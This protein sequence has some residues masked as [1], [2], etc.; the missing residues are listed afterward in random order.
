MPEDRQNPLGD[1]RVVHSDFTDV[2]GKLRMSDHL[3]RSVAAAGSPEVR[4]GQPL[5]FPGL[6]VFEAL[7]SILITDMMRADVKVL[8]ERR[9]QLRPI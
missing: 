4:L 9:N 5:D 1:L 3:H 2:A 7:Q 6:E 8:E